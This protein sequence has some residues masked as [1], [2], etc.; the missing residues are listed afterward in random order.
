[1]ARVAFPLVLQSPVTGSA[2]VGATATVT[3][4]VVGASLGSGPEAEIFTT[5]T[6][7]TKTANNK[8]VTDDTGRWTQGKGA[9]YAQYWLPQGA[10]DVLISGSGL[11]S[12]YVTRELVSGNGGAAALGIVSRAANFTAVPGELAEISATCEA[13]LPPPA[14][15][16]IFSLWAL[17]GATV[18]IKPTSGVFYGDFINA[19]ASIVLLSLQHVVVQQDGVN[20]FIIAGEPKRTD[21]YTA[22]KNYTKAEAEAGVEPSATR[23]ATVVISSTSEFGDVGTFTVGGVD[24]VT[25]SKIKSITVP[26]NPGQKW[27]VAVACSAITLLQ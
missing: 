10:Y 16:N 2:L 8:I 27:K 25:A 21:S 23:P 13:K 9:S 5:E 18:T 12:Y 3:K 15:N 1:M 17:P 11:T 20:Q 19:A 4:H 14:V 7:A 22:I 6:E 24:I 26:V